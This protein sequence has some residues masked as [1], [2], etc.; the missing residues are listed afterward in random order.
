MKCEFCDETPFREGDRRISKEW[1]LTTIFVR[2]RLLL[3][4]M[5]MKSLV[6]VV[7]DRQTL[8]LEVI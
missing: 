3:A 4:F 6:S 2:L 8:K 5:E 1:V 7:F